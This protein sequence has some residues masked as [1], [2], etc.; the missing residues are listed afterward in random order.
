VT[1]GDRGDQHVD[2][3]E[4]TVANSCHYGREYDLIRS[5]TS[6]DFEPLWITRR[7]TL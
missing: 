7:G 6:L 2:R 4:P 3:A 5:K 1:V